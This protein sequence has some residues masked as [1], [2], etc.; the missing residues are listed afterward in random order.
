VSYTVEPAEGKRYKDRQWGYRVK[1]DGETVLHVDTGGT[2]A[3]WNL[4][5]HGGYEADETMHVCDLDVLIGALTALRDSQANRA[6][7]ERW[8]KTPPEQG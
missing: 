8:G 2:G 1:R 6:H 4:L 5:M 7:C 3:C